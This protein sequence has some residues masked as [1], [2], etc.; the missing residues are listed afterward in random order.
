MD[1]VEDYSRRSGCG[2]IDSA[3]EVGL[4]VQKW[5]TSGK[6]QGRPDSSEGRKLVGGR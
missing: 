2:V 1:R 6:T 3:G 5:E 4:Q